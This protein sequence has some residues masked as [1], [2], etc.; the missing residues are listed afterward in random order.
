MEYVVEES[1]DN[2]PFI[3]I[4]DM[5][6]D[7]CNLDST[8]IP[9]WNG[10]PVHCPLRIDNV[11]VQLKDPNIKGVDCDKA[12]QDE[13][14]EVLEKHHKLFQKFAEYDKGFADKHN[15]SS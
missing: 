12:Y 10:I 8:I 14:K 11:I 5:S 6:P 15:I 3:S 1:C 4:S 13:I 9:S 2:C 7:F